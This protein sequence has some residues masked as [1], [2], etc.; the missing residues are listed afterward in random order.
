MA[1]ILYGVHGSQHGHAIR[2]L[3]LARRFSEHEF[4]FVTS[5]EAAEM[6]KGI[7]LLMWVEKELCRLTH[8]HF[9]GDVRK[10]AAL[11]GIDPAQLQ[12]HLAKE[13]PKKL[14]KK[15]S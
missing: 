10:A 11:L 3:T 14:L 2:A 1:R 4:L 9:N 6:A 5:E 13:E 8:R 7:D 15:A 12:S